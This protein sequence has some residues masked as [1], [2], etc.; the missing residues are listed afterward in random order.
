MKPKRAP[1]PA[2]PHIGP[3][4]VR[5][6]VAFNRRATRYKN[7]TRMAVML[8]ISFL[9]LCAVLSET[10]LGHYL[11]VWGGVL[12]LIGW[13]GFVGIA[14]F[15]LRLTCPACHRRLTPANGP[16]CPSCGSDQFAG[17]RHLQNGAG[18]KFAYC[19]VCDTT[20]YDGD[21][22]QPRSY[23]IRGCTHCRVTLD[24]TGV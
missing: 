2:A 6:L 8:L 13:L 11:D 24:K 18:K 9:C 16:Y 19:P 4:H 12:L 17:G 14:L 20:I 23:R 15:G 22:E 5:Y 1:Q 21:N 3:K 10:R 7:R